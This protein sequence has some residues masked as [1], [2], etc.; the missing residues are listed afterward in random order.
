[1]PPQR[2]YWDSDC[3]LAYLG[4]DTGKRGKCLGVLDAAEK[5]DVLIITSALTIAEVVYLKGNPKITPE[6]SDKICRFFENK[7]IQ[8]INLDRYLAEE[9]RQLL[10]IHPALKPKDA[11]HVASAIRA[12]VHL[13]DTFD[14]YLIGLSGKIGDN[15]LIIGEPNIPY[16]EDMFKGLEEN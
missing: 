8:P 5:G 7:Y 16:E 10:W 13:M 12:K 3:F 2:R 9:A 6:K 11:I 1:M 14:K 15:P 4:E